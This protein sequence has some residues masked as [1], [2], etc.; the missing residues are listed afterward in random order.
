MDIAWRIHMLVP[1]AAYD[2]APGSTEEEYDALDWKDPRPKPA[3][4][5][6]IETD[7]PPPNPVFYSP[8]K[9]IQVVDAMGKAEELEAMLAQAPARIR[10]RWQKVNEFNGND[11]DFQAMIATVQAAWGLTDE[12]RD[13]LL[14]Q[15]RI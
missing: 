10:L 4:Q 6:I 2:G 12:Q 15:A 3:W 11:Q 8:D 5:D 9:L 13:A 7:D 1:A 14:A